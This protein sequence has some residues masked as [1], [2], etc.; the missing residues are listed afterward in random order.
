L[1]LFIAGDGSIGK[2]FTANAVLGHLFG[3][4][5]DAS[6]FVTGRDEFN[7][8]LLASPLWTCHDTQQTADTATSRN[9]FT[10]RLKRI[11]A[12]R[13]LISRTMFKEGIDV[14]WNGRVIVTLNTDPE[15]LRMLPDLEQTTLNKVLLLRANDPKIIEFPTDDEVKAELPHFGS[16]LRDYEIPANIREARF[17]LV[18]WHHPDLLDAAHAESP[19]TSALEVISIWR[20]EY[21]S[22]VD[23]SVVDWVGNSSEMLQQMLLT[24]GS[25]SLVRGQFR[26]G[27]AL[28][29][30][31]NKLI[32]QHVGWIHKQPGGRRHY[33]IERP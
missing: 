27:T 30:N 2:N 17:G 7:G 26:N 32:G 28:G 13:E 21:F 33:R 22:S 16:Y 24:P 8:N 25:E 9:A 29:R 23:K 10:Q 15:S 3:G 11:I 18:A 14:P 6:K 1:A 5:A 20:K 4:H 12:D 19:T 31:L